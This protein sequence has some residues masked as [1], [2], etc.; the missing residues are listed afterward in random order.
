MT[1]RTARMRREEIRAGYAAEE[2]EAAE[3]EA[4]ETAP[5]LTVEQVEEIARR[6][7]LETRSA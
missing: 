6:I 3:A 2:A 5:V 7:A 1:D 4:A